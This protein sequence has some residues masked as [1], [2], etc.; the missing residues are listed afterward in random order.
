MKKKK[1]IRPGVMG[2]FGLENKMGLPLLFSFALAYL[3]I[4][5]GGVNLRLFHV[6]SVFDNYDFY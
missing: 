4:P 6:G 3:M 1:K 2:W 5:G